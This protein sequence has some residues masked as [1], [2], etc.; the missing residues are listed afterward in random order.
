MPEAGFIAFFV[1]GLVLRN[2]DV[3]VAAVLDLP[4]DKVDFKRQVVLLFLKGRNC[5]CGP[6][7]CIS[8]SQYS[9]Y[10]EKL[11]DWKTYRRR[12]TSQS[13]RAEYGLEV[14]KSLSKS[15]TKKYGKGFTKINLYNFYSFYKE[16]PEIFHSLSG[17]SD[18]LLSWTHYTVL[19]QVKGR[20]ARERKKASVIF[21]P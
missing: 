10:T 5:R 7:T 9:S 13:G 12:E 14:M 3:L 20:Q 11:T 16:Y 21:I 2:M 18:Q 17:K 6:T 19:L 4:G 1:F 15:L 8:I